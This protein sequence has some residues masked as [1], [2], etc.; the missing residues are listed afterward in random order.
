MKKAMGLVL[1]GL[2][3]TGALGEASWAA[4]ESEETRETIAQRAPAR[5]VAP[6]RVTD[7]GAATILSSVAPGLG[8]SYLSGWKN[9]FPWVE[10]LLSTSLMGTGGVAIS[11]MLSGVP[12][13]ASAAPWVG[14]AATVAGT[15]MRLTS[16]IDAASGVTAE[17]L[18]FD[19]WS[20]PD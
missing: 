18:R 1:I 10:C 6:A 17:N 19:F 20:L 3:L 5:S 16:M 15:A 2:L 4:E 7:R 12:S 11:N 14:L 9:G 8:E 13:L